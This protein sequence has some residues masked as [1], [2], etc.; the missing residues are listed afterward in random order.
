[1]SQLEFFKTVEQEE[2]LS[3]R[4]SEFNDR[5]KHL[6]AQYNTVLQ[7]LTTNG[8]VEG[9]HYELEGKGSYITKSKDFDYGSWRENLTETFDVKWFD[10]HINFKWYYYSQYDNKIE[11][12]KTRVDFERN[13]FN[14]YGLQGN[15]R[16][17]KPST[18][19]SKIEESKGKAEAK[20]NAYSKKENAI[21]KAMN[22]LEAKFPNAEVKRYGWDEKMIEITF[23]NNN[24]VTFN[25]WS[26]GS[27]SQK[28]MHLS[29]INKIE[30][31]DDKLK[32]IE[33][34]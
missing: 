2:R 23:K 29:T 28:R 32:L 33:S 5:Q 11:L 17:I 31:L 14:I 34:L 9:V 18:L 15:Y 21:V 3:R 7:L 26:D 1:M 16:Y 19:L 4:I 6:E 13:K 8:F 20:F 10:G 24:S 12:R 25:V 30:N 22:D 27:L